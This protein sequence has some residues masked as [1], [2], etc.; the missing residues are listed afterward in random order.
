MLNT[1]GREMGAERGSQALLFSWLCSCPLCP[2]RRAQAGLT[3]DI[4][5]D[6]RVKTGEGM[7]MRNKSKVSFRGWF[8]FKWL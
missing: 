3:A 2:R 7:D 5:G 4:R 6:V 1:P 8:F